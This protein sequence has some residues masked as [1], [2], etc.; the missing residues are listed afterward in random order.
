M[1]EKPVLIAWHQFF[2]ATGIPGCFS[3]VFL[4]VALAFNYCLLTF[5]VFIICL[6]FPILIRYMPLG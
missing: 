3:E 1:G 4:V 6:P 2:P 5:K